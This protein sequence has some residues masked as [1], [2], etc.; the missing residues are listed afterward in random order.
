M[1]VKKCDVCGKYYDENN[2]ECGLDRCEGMTLTGIQTM[3]ELD[4]DAF[5]DLCDVCVKKV[6]AWIKGD[7][8]VIHKSTIW[9][10]D[11]KV[12]DYEE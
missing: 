4:I 5:V 3:K 1:D 7:A 8:I 6:T 9:A 2:N 10:M 12:E 11:E